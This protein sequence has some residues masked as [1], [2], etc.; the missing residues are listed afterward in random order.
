MSSGHLRLTIVAALTG[1]IS[2]AVFAG[3]SLA[4]WRIF[5]YPESAGEI[6][7]QMVWLGHVIGEKLGQCVLVAVLAFI[8]ARL[9]HPSWKIGVVTAVVS[10]LVFQFISIAVYVTRFGFEAYRTFNTF[11]GT[12]QFN[13]PVAFLFG[14]LAVL[15]QYRRERKGPTM[16]SSEPSH[17]PP[18]ASERLRGPGR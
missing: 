14:F 17:R 3:C 2:F 12:L 18:V 11:W 15:G 4:A 6:Q 13:I 7:R 5:P 10:V 1:G 16:R 8:A 9:H